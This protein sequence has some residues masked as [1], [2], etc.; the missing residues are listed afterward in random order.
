MQYRSEVSAL[1]LLHETQRT[2]V[3]LLVVGNVRVVGDV[4]R[5][6]G[7]SVRSPGS[8]TGREQGSLSYF[9]LTSEKKKNKTNN[10]DKRGCDGPQSMFALSFGSAHTA[11]TRGSVHRS[12]PPLT[13]ACR[14]TKRRAFWPQNAGQQPRPPAARYL[15]RRYRLVIAQ[16]QIRG[17]RNPF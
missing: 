1:S 4:R 2:R 14:A 16:L 11:N 6:R 13:P 7:R 15:F 10:G 3:V 12:I 17:P 5:F 9:P 8:R